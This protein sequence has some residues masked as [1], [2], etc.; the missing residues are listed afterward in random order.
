MSKL[1][2]VF[3]EEIEFIQPRV[4]VIRILNAFLPAY[5]FIRL[6]TRLIRWLGF[7]IGKGVSF[8]DVP[9][10][11]GSKSC[12]KDLRIGND[13]VINIQCLFDLG[14]P[15]SIGNRV[16]IGQR[17]M[18]ITGAHQ[19]GSRFQRLGPLDP[20]PIIIQD[21]VWLGAGAVILPGVTVG[22]GAVVAAGALVTK[23]VSENSLVAGIPA[24][25]I[26]QLPDDP[27]A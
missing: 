8:F 20:Q 13:S 17:V 11:T 26:R 22:E 1:G 16:G 3:R 14:A 6:R 4:L 5:T 19:I 10:I 12:H 24:K 2:Q 25:V 21:G 27:G 18:L 9:V 7:E 15:I 23:D